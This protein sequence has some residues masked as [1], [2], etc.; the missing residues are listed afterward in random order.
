MQREPLMTYECY[1]TAVTIEPENAVN[2]AILWDGTRPRNNKVIGTTWYET[3][4]KFDSYVNGNFTT[5]YD[6][7]AGVGKLV[8]SDL[9]ENVEIV[10]P[11]YNGEAYYMKLTITSQRNRV[12]YKIY[13]TSG[14]CINAATLLFKT[15][16]D[17]RDNECGSCYKG[18]KDE[19]SKKDE[20]DKKDEEISRSK[21]RRDLGCAQMQFT[22]FPQAEPFPVCARYKSCI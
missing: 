15:C 14:L 8:S 22:R 12:V 2:F 1:R 10:L 21:P 18:C 9:Q 19:K 3:R 16:Y 5:E 11:P 4:D 20:K 7:N 6:Q 13:D 17:Y